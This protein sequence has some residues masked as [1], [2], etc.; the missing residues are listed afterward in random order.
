MNYKILKDHR[1]FFALLRVVNFF[2]RDFLKPI[3]L[4]IDHRESLYF[5]LI[6]YHFNKMLSLSEA[7]YYL[8]RLGFLNEVDCLLRSF[9]DTYVNINFI[10][11]DSPYRSLLFQLDELNEFLDSRKKLLSHY[12]GEKKK[13]IEESIRETT[14]EQDRLIDELKKFDEKINYTKFKWKEF[15]ISDKA[16]EIKLKKE[17]DFLFVSWSRL[18]HPSSR[19]APNY[20]KFDKGMIET[21]I[22]PVFDDGMIRHR[23]LFLIEYLLDMSYLANNAFKLDK[24]NDRLKLKNIEKLGKYFNELNPLIQF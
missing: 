7:S 18:V 11:K 2:V 12:N 4:R 3:R 17:Y 16:K 20:L 15:S 10:R 14:L 6:L 24:P 1:R 9:W 22:A 19:G 8:M 13:M 23:L 5:S 21:I